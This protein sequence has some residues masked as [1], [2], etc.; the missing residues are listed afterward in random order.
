[1]KSAGVSQTGQR[2]QR[3]QS[4]AGLDANSGDR[5]EDSVAGISAEMAASATAELDKHQP[6]FSNASDTDT[7]T[8]SDRDDN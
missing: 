4:A 7:D 3:Q 6:A 2:I 5:R 1:M 8:D